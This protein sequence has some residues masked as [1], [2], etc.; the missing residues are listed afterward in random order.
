MLPSPDTNTTYLPERRVRYQ[1]DA[2]LEL[3]AE[4]NDRDNDCRRAVRL[5]TRVI[6]SYGFSLS[7]MISA[8]AHARVLEGQLPTQPE[9]RVQTRWRTL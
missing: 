7:R 3:K 8:R 2:P 1:Q 6:L 5:F 4:R 9:L